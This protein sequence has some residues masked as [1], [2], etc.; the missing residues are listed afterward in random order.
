[1]TRSAISIALVVL[2][3]VPVLVTTRSALADEGAPKTDN[4]ARAQQLFDSALADAQAGNFAS[5]CPKFLASQEVDP[6]TSTLLN[7][8]A[9]YEKNGQTA[10]A[11]GAYREA[12]G[13]ARKISRADWES[14]ARTHA[15]ALEPKLMRLTI[16]VPQP[17]RVPDLKVTR[18][19]GHIAAGEWGVAI[20]IDPGEHVITATA[21]GYAPWET[22]IKMGDTIST[23]AVPVL[24]LLPAPPVET[25]MVP[26]RPPMQP[27]SWWTPLHTAGVV[28][29]GV[30]VI[31][32]VTG[33][34]LGL[35][36]KGNYDDARARCLNGAASCP[37][38]AVSDSDSAYGMATGATVVFVVGAVAA[39]GG[40][41]LVLLSPSPATQTSASLRIGPGSVGVVGRW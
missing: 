14:T 30:G 7:L 25:A 17:S 2:L 11:W 35:V 36:A 34:V 23:V 31:G 29:A 4:R 33:S 22:R 13:L 3:S 12:E 5:A 37:S 41:A 21:P 28:V 8:A 10:S 39:A 16:Q 24:E 15:E 27:G 32:L 1:M 40:A 20:P 9:C 18:D 19:G 6:K 38:S 26:E